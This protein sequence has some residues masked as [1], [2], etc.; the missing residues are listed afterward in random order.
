M[1]FVVR[2][3]LLDFFRFL[4]KKRFFHVCPFSVECRKQSHLFIS[5]SECKVRKFIE[6]ESGELPPPFVEKNLADFSDR[7]IPRCLFFFFSRTD[8]CCERFWT[9]FPLWP[10]RWVPGLRTA[11]KPT[12]WVHT[13]RSITPR[14]PA[15]FEGG[16][17]ASRGGGEIGVRIN[18]PARTMCN[19]KYYWHTKNNKNVF[20]RYVTRS[21]PPP[22]ALTFRSVLIGWIGRDTVFEQRD[23]VSRSALLALF[24]SSY[25]WPDKKVLFCVWEKTRC[26][27]NECR[28]YVELRAYRSHCHQCL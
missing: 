21:P 13:P 7:T 12:A 11:P 17:G 28:M 9:E 22:R 14:A 1:F 27:H 8:M 16:G 4:E 3:L 2:K 23:C 6:F 15:L 25:E 18:F 5:Q 24:A 26:L 10:G 20:Y 19:E